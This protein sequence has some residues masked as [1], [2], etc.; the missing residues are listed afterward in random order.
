MIFPAKARPT[1]QSHNAL[2]FVHFAYFTLRIIKRIWPVLQVC[3]P[4]SRNCCQQH[5]PRNKSRAGNQIT[6]HC[7][8]GATKLASPLWIAASKASQC[9]CSGHFSATSLLWCFACTCPHCSVQHFASPWL[10]GYLL[11]KPSQVDEITAAPAGS[12]GLY[13]GV[14]LQSGEAECGKADSLSDKHLEHGDHNYF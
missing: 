7:Y 14:S 13:V 3:L 8:L 10:C 4:N 9:I 2:Q 11:Q 5:H 1:E 6:S 12:G